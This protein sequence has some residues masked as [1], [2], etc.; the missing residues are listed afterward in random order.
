MQGFLDCGFDNI[1]NT[2]G[3]ELQDRTTSLLKKLPMRSLSRLPRARE[4]REARWR[5]P[6]GEMNPNNKVGQVLTSRTA[7]EGQEHQA[8]RMTK[9]VKQVGDVRIELWRVGRP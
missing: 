6:R 7:R 8:G 4:Y 2:A 9:Y 5:T 1:A 3:E